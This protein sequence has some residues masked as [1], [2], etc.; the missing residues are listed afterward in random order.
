MVS[1][2][3]IELCPCCTAETH[4][5][6]VRRVERFHGSSRGLWYRRS[7]GMLKRYEEIPRIS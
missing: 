7:L 3:Y 4:P 2:E 1:R 5:I 6:R